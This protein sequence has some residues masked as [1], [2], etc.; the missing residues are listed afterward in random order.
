MASVSPHIDDAAARRIIQT[1]L[2]RSLIVEAS[3]G[4]GKTTEMVGRIVAVL[5]EGLA[6][7][8]QVAAVTFT[9]KAAGE[10][11]LRL[12]QGLDRAR[13]AATEA[14]HRQNLE[15]A[16]KRLEEASIG[17]IHSFCAQLLRERPVEAVVDPA[18]EELT[19]LESA[20]LY[21][22]AFRTWMQAR[23]NADSPGLRRALTRL[24]W[25][26][27]SRNNW[28]PGPPM[29]RIAR[30]G[31]T[32][33]EWR[34]YPAPW[35]RDPFER[36]TEVRT[37]VEA[38]QRLAEVSVL[39][40]DRAN[41]LYRSLQPVRDFAEWVRRADRTGRRDSD[42]LEALLLK[43]LVE[44]GRENL[45]GSGN[46]YAPGV[47]RADVLNARER[48]LQKLE[49]FRARA[50]AD[51]AVSL[52]EEFSGLVAEFDE[53]KRKAGK[54]DFVD[55]LI[56][57]RDLVRGNRDVRRHLQTRFTHL[58]VDE[59]QD[60][61][62][63]QAEILLLLA[64]NDSAEADWLNVTPVPGKLFVVGDP[65]QSIYKFRRADVVLY[66]EIK[67][68]LVERGVD[69]VYLTKSFRSV[70]PI[71]QAVNAAF[72][73]E[74]TGDQQAGQAAYVPLGEVRNAL[75]G[76]PAVIALPAPRPYG[77][78]KVSK[79]KINDCLPGAVTG[80]VEWLLNDS[81][82][83]IADPREKGP[84]GAEKLIPIAS[85]HVAIL[86]RRF[87]NGPDDL[88]RS[89][90]RGLEARGIP[91]LLMGSKS[92]HKRE[93]VE[94]VRAAL[95]AVEWPEDE[96]SVYA[97]LK[98]SLFAIND[99][100]L[101]RFRAEYK[102]LHPFLPLPIEIEPDFVPV[103]SALRVLAD[104]HRGRN[105]RPAAETVNLL[106]AATRAHA[107]FA[108]RPAGHQILANVSRV[109]DLARS[110]ELSGGISF[111]GFV[112]ELTSQAE[113]A[114]SA[115]AP[116]LEEGA[117]GVRLMTV[118]TAK[119]LEF[120]VVILADMTANIQASNPDRYID[121]TGR[122]CATRL[123]GCA[124]W[125][126]LEHEA[127]ERERERSEGVRVAY[128]AATRARDLLVIPAVGDE[129]RS[130]W[131]GP[132]NPVIYPE[133]EQ[134]RHSRPAAGCPR[135]GAATVLDRPIDM[136]QEG[137]ISVKPGLHTPRLGEN[138]VVW[139]DPATLVLDAP[140]PAGLRQEELLKD[141]T[142]AAKEGHERYRTWSE[143]RARFLE[144]G[145][146]KQFDIFTASE[147]GAGPDGLT[148]EVRMETVP[149][150]ADRPAGNR[151]GT[152]VHAILR[153]VEFGAGTVEIE[154]LALM[155]ARILGA[156]LE[157][158]E[159]AAEAV[160]RALQS[161][162]MQRAAQGHEVHR[163]WPVV[164]RLPDGR[165]LE[166][167]I[168]LAF[169]EEGGWWIVDFKSDAD[170]NARRKHYETQLAWYAMA[171]ARLTGKAARC[172][173]LAV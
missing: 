173:L 88:T 57:A 147:A 25:P 171:V 135:F 142:A 117:E 127:E 139:W 31:W 113:H 155:H 37:L 141:G 51:L 50:D 136:L 164:L 104:L 67:R 38:V 7:I 103:A 26:A 52:R 47:P 115:E 161:P 79:E 1:E 87:V 85:Q 36:E 64:A 48:L 101:L 105:W 77:F 166:G 14:H 5:R 98:G 134:W 65:K 30:A 112:E 63:L 172:C 72:S 106:L 89:Y 159:A 61:D 49:E 153:D 93:E 13:T 86:F 6:R 18:F 84:D 144:A 54:L 83:K 109:C 90:V 40:T 137:E 168:D 96:L 46:L 152:L 73:L 131:V 143:E 154:G 129:E 100:V 21:R 33:I 157:E 130:G 114:D 120:P 55:L 92:F 167:S 35:R 78:Q 150:A 146:R 99:A 11:K 133:K 24:A 81:G 9:H 41:K 116:V 39:C 163:E 69:A 160:Y 148:V 17:T 8:E 70:R 151:F 43:L 74:M 28:E 82:W 27:V 56:R 3:A 71:Q 107:G 110:F 29:D 149:R 111:R 138:E 140:D 91:H 108:L 4:T 45:K 15:D 16:L 123:L 126:L 23:L 12:R 22:R 53:L 119:G 68:R 58:F 62:P 122:L 60:T 59:I 170:V 158:R 156:D 44:Q 34:D 125:E 124:P 165:I 32:V 97:A 162:T 121:G 10:M 76:Q 132:L 169:L 102:R 128:V 94:A 42:T 66:E 118:H 95:T 80:F 145:A 2:G 19:E 75:Q 20:Q